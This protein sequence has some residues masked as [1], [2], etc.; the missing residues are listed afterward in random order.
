MSIYFRE[1]NANRYSNKMW[2]EF[3][4]MSKTITIAKVQEVIQHHRKFIWSLQIRDRRLL[5]LLILKT[6]HVYPISMHESNM[7]LV[8]TNYAGIID[9]LDEVIKAKRPELSKKK[10]H[11]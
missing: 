11:Y 6:F 4:K 1:F 8:H 9:K 2:K 5:C 3:I 10:R 7:L